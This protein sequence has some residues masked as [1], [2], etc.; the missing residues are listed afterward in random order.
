MIHFDLKDSLMKFVA[1]KVALLSVLLVGCGSGTVSDEPVDVEVS[2]TPI[3]ATLDKIAESGQVGSEV[4]EIQDAVAAMPN[5]EE[6]TPLVDELM[7]AGSPAEVKKKAKAL[8]E[9]L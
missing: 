8:A 6:L 2:Q 5:H 3:Q 4:M 7:K 1:C 9:K